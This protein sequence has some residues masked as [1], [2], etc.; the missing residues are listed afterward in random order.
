MATKRKVNRGGFHFYNY[1]TLL[2]PK[3]YV[4]PVL[5]DILCP[6]DREPVQNNGH[7]EPAITINLGPHYIYRIWGDR[8]KEDARHQFNTNKSKEHDWIIGDSYVEPPYQP[9]SYSLA[10]DG[11]AQILP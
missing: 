11:P 4:A 3:G 6:K 7:L 9:H 5:F 10:E 2:N 8:S 1:Y